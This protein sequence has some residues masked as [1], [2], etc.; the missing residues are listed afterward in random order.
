MQTNNRPNRV[1]W[2]RGRSFA[3]ATVAILAT[4]AV[5]WA[6]AGNLD[7][8]FNNGGVVV[9]SG[10][11]GSFGPEVA[12]Q[13][14]GKIVACGAQTV[15][16]ADP[17]GH[18]RSEWWIRRLNADGTDD[19]GFG[20]GGAVA[21]FGDGADWAR[22]VAIDASGGLV[23]LGKTSSFVVTKRSVSA[24]YSLSLARLNPSGALDT[25]FG[26]N[27]VVR[28]APPGSSGGS[29]NPDGALALD[30][31]NIVVAGVAY[32]TIDRKGTTRTYPFL[33]RYGAGG[34]LDTSFGSGGFSV[35]TRASEDTSWTYAVARQSSG[36]YVLAQ[37]RTSVAW[38]ITRYLPSG[39]VDT[40]FAPILAPGDYI[41]GLSI[42][43]SDRIV[44]TGRNTYANGQFDVLVRRYSA[45]GVVDGSFGSGGRTLVHADY[46]QNC[47]ADPVFQSDQKV[48][49]GANLVSSTG[50]VVAATFRLDDGGLLDTS[51]GAGGI[52]DRIDLFP[53]GSTG[54]WVTGAS[55][56]GIAPDGRIVLAGGAHGSSWNWMLAR[57]DAN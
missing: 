18:A 30:D 1:S 54:S 11:A 40:N 47:W 8:T 49:I 5:V 53:S 17:T 7:P 34:A 16:G 28:V 19:T 35:D 12:I 37:R 51:Y 46:N 42:D 48:V 41:G 44:A 57:F 31:G 52:G 24:T 25:S 3:V 6:A 10:T 33:A 21:L 55:S 2:R 15:S 26:S 23:V 29:S 9:T 20:T 36:H 27:G 13:P 56:V 32:F 38:V 43:G 22:R 4:T 50:K 45:S 39:L 14:D